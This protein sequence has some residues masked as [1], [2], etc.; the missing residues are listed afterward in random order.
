M[1]EG[2]NVLG[3]RGASQQR[4]RWRKPA[5]AQLRRRRQRRPRFE[6]QTIDTPDHGAVL[7]LRTC[8]RVLQVRKAPRRVGGLDD[9]RRSLPRRDGS[10]GCVDG[11]LAR[12]DVYAGRFDLGPGLRRLVAQG[13]VFD[14]CEFGECL[15]QR[16][17]GGSEALLR[18]Y[19]VDAVEW[20][21][22]PLQRGISGVEVHAGLRHGFPR[23]RK[24]KS[25]VHGPHC[26]DA[27]YR[28]RECIFG[29]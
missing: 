24:K 26:F 21:P 25:R 16:S 7:L 13:G 8:D 2:G 9:R 11:R 6:R 28:R 4:C 17:L 19:S 22:H 20:G 23:L 14:D 15:G 29:L 10:A 1:E 3:K 27:P 18:L 12:F 5:G